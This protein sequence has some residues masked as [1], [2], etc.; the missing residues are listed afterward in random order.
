MQDDVVFKHSAATGTTLATKS[1]YRCAV[2]IPR[3]DGTCHRTIEHMI[4]DL[5]GLTA[6]FAKPGDSGAL[7]YDARAKPVGMVF[8]GVAGNAACHLNPVQEGLE[9]VLEYD[10]AALSPLN[11]GSLTLYMDLSDLMTSIKQR[12]NQYDVQFL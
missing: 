12:L 8:A 4:Y 11:L 2:R 6:S 3:L 10:A 9:F 5:P 7:I 1:S